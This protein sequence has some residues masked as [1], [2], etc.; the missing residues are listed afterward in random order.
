MLRWFGGLASLLAFALPRFVDFVS[1]MLLIRLTALMARSVVIDLW[2]VFWA[3]LVAV[4]DRVV[5]AI[6]FWPDGRLTYVADFTR[7]RV[8]SCLSLLLIARSS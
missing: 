1:A 8:S 2:V 7:S 6:L 3:S 5:G 4:V